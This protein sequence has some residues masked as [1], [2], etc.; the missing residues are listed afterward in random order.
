MWCTFQV[1]PNKCPSSRWNWCAHP[2][3]QWNNLRLCISNRECTSILRRYFVQCGHSFIHSFIRFFNELGTLTVQKTSINWKWF[4]A[5]LHGLPNLIIVAQPLY[6]NFWMTLAGLSD[7]R[8]ESRLSMFGK[9]VAS[10]V[11]ISVDKFSKST[12]FTRFSDA[13]TFTT[14]SA[15]TDP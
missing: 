8:K 3:R 7:R 15:R 4:S 9:A 14:I 1:D 13:S 11:S 10:W 5:V 12:K 2:F 6:P